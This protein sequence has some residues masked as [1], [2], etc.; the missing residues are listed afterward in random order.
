MTNF[1]YGLRAP[2]S[3][4]QYPARLKVYLDFLGLKGNISEQASQ[5]LD[6][7][8]GDILWAQT[9]IMRFIESQKERARAGQIA[10]VTIRNYYKAIK[11]L[12]DMNEL[13]L[14]W[15]KITKGLPKQVNASNDRTPS[16]EE[17]KK[18]IEYP[19][20]RI[21]PIIF[22]FV[23]SGIRLGAWDFLKWK[24]IIPLH[25][26]DR[27]IV[28]AKIVVY[29][30]EDDQ[31][32][33]FITS[34][35]FLALKEWIDFRSSYGEKITGES[36]L[37][38]DLWKTTNV[39]YGAKS[40]LAKLP[41]KLKS[42][43]I[44]RLIERALWE[45]GI[46]QS[47]ENGQRRHE[48]KAAHGFRKLFKTI[49]EQHMRPINVEILMGHNIGVSASYYKP[50]EHEVLE[51]YLRAVDHLTVNRDKKVLENQISALTE[52]QDEITLIKIKHEKEMQQMDQKLDN[53]MALIRQNPKFANVKPESLKKKLK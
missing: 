43:G 27:T 46:R 51:D 20:R 33:S 45:Q 28:A 26:N 36:W 12:C 18:L 47:L 53:I 19:D 15:K 3:R 22:T 4:R 6:K 16:I 48:W 7:A 11:L 30:G 23:S 8:K 17:I 2:E 31:Y 14:G 25:G 5:F 34:E 24:H 32:Y 1:M 52:K 50:K 29:A 49:A 41:Q 9:S 38:R 21:K 35:A 42:S 10:F 40:G 44:K 13:T 37:M 39:E